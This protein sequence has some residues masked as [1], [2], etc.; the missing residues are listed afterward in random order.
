MF[1]QEILRDPSAKW[2]RSTPAAEEA[3]R[4]LIA[5]CDFALPDEYLELLRYS[6]GGEGSLGVEPGWFQI[7]PAEE[8]VTCNE[9]YEVSQALPGDFAIGSSGGGEMLT[10][11][12]QAGPPWPVYMIPFIGMCEEDCLE[13]ASN[14]VAF[15]AAFGKEID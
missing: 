14:F 10:F 11:R 2:T 9:E 8:V 3:I 5:R 1:L 7:W 12:K 15:V 13:I 6:N 4:Q